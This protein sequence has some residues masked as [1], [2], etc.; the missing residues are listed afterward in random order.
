MVYHDIDPDRIR[1]IRGQ[2]DRREW[3][4]PAQ[5]LLRHRRL[6]V[7]NTDFPE[8]SISTPEPQ[9]IE[10]QAHNLFSS[11]LVVGMVDR[12]H[13]R[14]GGKWHRCNMAPLTPASTTSVAKPT[15]EPIPAPTRATTVM[16]R[17]STTSPTIRRRYFPSKR[18]GETVPRMRFMRILGILDPGIDSQIG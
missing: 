12:N 10:L 15:R 6:E 4:H 14:L 1:L 8:K 3:D 18:Y 16:V 11:I 2:S 17:S 7:T 9:S 13:C 5:S